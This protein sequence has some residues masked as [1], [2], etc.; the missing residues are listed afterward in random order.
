MWE[1]E[2][3]RGFM[4]GVRQDNASSAALC[5]RL[6]ISDTDWTYSVCI[7]PEMLGRKNLTK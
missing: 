6:G 5:N 1:K 2:G 3:A 4:T 7:D